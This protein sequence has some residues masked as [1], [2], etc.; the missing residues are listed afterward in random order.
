MAHNPVTVSDK[1]T[2]GSRPFDTADV[3]WWT[4]FKVEKGRKYSS[5]SR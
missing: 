5:A 2:Y 3:C 1:P 4:G